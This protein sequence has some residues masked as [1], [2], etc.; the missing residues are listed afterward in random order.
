MYTL[1][2]I[3]NKGKVTEFRDIYEEI[4]WAEFVHY[5]GESLH[6]RVKHLNQITDRH[7]D[8]RI[9]KSHIPPPVLPF[10]HD[11]NYL[12]II[13]NPFDVIAS[14]REFFANHGKKF[15][16]MWGGFPPGAGEDVLTP[17]D[18]WEQMVLRDSGDGKPLAETFV[19][20]FVSNWWPYRNHSNVLILH[21]SDRIKD[22][23]TQINRLAS[24]LNVT[25]TNEEL[26][27]VAEQVS[28]KETKKVQ[29]RL[30]LRYLLEPFKE[31]GLVAKDVFP[32][33][34]D[35]EG[36]MVNQGPKRKGTEQLSQNMREGVTEM[37]NKTYPPAMIEWIM[38]GGRLPVEADVLPPSC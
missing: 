37:M 9:I 33:R 29:D 19:L 24:F 17:E 18:E 28:F 21:Y 2:Q 31:R 38:N 23:T 16:D 6:D 34:T 8:M 7:S 14:C 5:P 15:A 35:K 36:T 27:R 20:D 25:L 1:H 3:R 22:D 26:H 30:E 13:R 4:P 10:R 32:L 11:V 12:V